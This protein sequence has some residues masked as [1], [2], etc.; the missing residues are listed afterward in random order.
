MDLLLSLSPAL[1]AGAFL[2]MC[3]CILTKRTGQSLSSAFIEGLGWGL[4]FLFSYVVEIL[5]VA[6]VGLI[7]IA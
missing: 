4:G 6:N 5:A 1:A 7:S 2:I 3:N